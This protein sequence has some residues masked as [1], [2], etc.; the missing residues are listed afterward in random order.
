MIFEANTL[1]RLVRVYKTF[2]KHTNQQTN[3]MKRK[4]EEKKRKEE[5]P[6]T[7]TLIKQTNKQKNPDVCYLSVVIYNHVLLKG[8]RQH[9]CEFYT[10]SSFHGE[11]RK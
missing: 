11:N 2:P 9:A 7:N 6:F 4:K 8:V 1:F 3:K 10:C 5:T